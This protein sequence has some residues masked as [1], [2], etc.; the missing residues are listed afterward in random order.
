ML[1]GVVIDDT[2]LFNGKLQERQ[3]FYNY[4]HGR[5]RRLLISRGAAAIGGM[6][7]V[8]WLVLG[9]LDLRRTRALVPCWLGTFRPVPAAS[10]LPFWRKGGSRWTYGRA[11]GSAVRTGMGK[12][13]HRSTATLTTHDARAAR[14]ALDG[15]C[16]VRGFR[17]FRR[18]ARAGAE[19]PGRRGGPAGCGLCLRVPTAPRALCHGGQQDTGGRGETLLAV[20]EHD[21][22]LARAEGHW[23][24]GDGGEGGAAIGGR[25]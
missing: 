11:C 10:E 15:R 7:G 23:L 20:G 16:W 19:F 2:A 14:F 12:W 8:S 24:A 17:E 18:R 25:P 6:A 4:Q 21:P 1:E 22:D 5:R 3:G 9:A 13:A